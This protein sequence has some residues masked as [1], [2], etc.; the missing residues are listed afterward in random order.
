MVRAL[1]LA[2]GQGASAAQPGGVPAGHGDDP[3]GG[4]YADGSLA[5][6]SVAEFSDPAPDFLD[7]LEPDAPARDLFKAAEKRQDSLFRETNVEALIETFDWLTVAVE[8]AARERFVHFD[9]IFADVMKT[10][11]GFD[12]IVGNPPWAKPSWNE[13]LVLADIDPLYAGLSASDAKKALSDAL[14]KAPVVRREGRQVSATTAFLQDFVST[15][16]AMEVTSSDVMNPF[17]GGGSNNLYRCFI[18]LAFRLVAP[19]GYAALIHQDGHLGDPKSGMFRRHWYS[20]ISKHFE[21]SNLIAS[22]NFSEV[23][24]ELHFSLNIYRGQE[25][26]IS[27]D[28]GTNFFLASQIDESYNHDG[29]GEIPSLKGDDGKFDL[30]GHSQRIVRIDEKALEVIHSLTED[31]STPIAEARFIQPYSSH[32]LHVF[33]QMASCSTLDAAIPTKT[34]TVKTT[35][36][37]HTQEISLWQMNRLLDQTNAQKD[38]II[39]KETTFGTPEQMVLQGPMFHVGIPFYKT[40]R[41]VSRTNADYDAIDLTRTSDDYLP[42]TN[43]VPALEQQEYRQRL[44]RCRWDTTKSHV[45]FFRIAFRAMISV[46]G[47]RSLINALIPKGFAHV[48]SVESIAFGRD[49]DLVNAAALYSSIPLDFYIKASAKQNFHDSDA[50]GLPWIDVGPT[51]QHRILRLS[52]LTSSY[53]ELWNGYANSLRVL[54][55]SSTD[56]RLSMDGAVE[57]PRSWDRSAGLRLE[58]ARRQALIEIDVLVAQ[59][60]GL[61]LNQLIEIYRVYFPVMQRKE[62]STYFDQKGRIVWISAKGMGNVGWFDK[63][64]KSPTRAAWDKILAENPSELTWHRHRRYDARRPARGDPPLRRPLHPMRPDRGLQA[65]LGAFRAAEIRGRRLI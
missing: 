48:N 45:D 13:G 58:F 28:Q 27:F 18:D 61:S 31:S 44:S 17:A 6:P 47:E 14:P 16:G 38:G 40:P 42:R 11:G 29:S 41:R 56:P 3:R 54:P 15:R 43:L 32:M 21:F 26:K 30:R 60:L 25:Q 36:G 10:R 57:G 50:Q 33:R 35:S 2:A 55:W 8:V 9:L 65:R 1:A 34:V 53:A 64:G 7:Q 49:R 5:A 22:K 62:R 52:C 39:R 51:A 12:V 20:R 59:A 4:L 46:N 23:H 37:A 24:F 63:K 19:E